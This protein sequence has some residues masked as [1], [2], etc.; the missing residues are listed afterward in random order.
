MRSARLWAAAVALALVAALVP[1]VATAAPGDPCEATYN[2]PMN[3]TDKLK[4]YLDCRLDRLES[5]APTVTVTVTASPSA[6]PSQ[7]PSATPTA[8]PASSPFAGAPTARPTSARHFPRLP[9]PNSP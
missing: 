4:R 8:T 9:P 3:S 5:P 2:A 7:S 1:A 6:T